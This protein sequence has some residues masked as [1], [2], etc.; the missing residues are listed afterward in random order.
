MKDVSDIVK[1]YLDNNGYDG[2]YSPDGGCACL[3]E[4]LQPCGENFCD[5]VPGIKKTF[6]EL[7]EKQKEVLDPD[8]GFYMASKDQP[9][10]N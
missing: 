5:C 1:E 6:S 10:G 2:L 8:A 4:D 9:N 3:K 7:T